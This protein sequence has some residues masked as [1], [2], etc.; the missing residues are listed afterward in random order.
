M[1]VRSRESYK[2]LFKEVGFIGTTFWHFGKGGKCN[3]HMT[4]FLLH[5]DV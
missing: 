5:K 3:E 2:W 4:A 1:K